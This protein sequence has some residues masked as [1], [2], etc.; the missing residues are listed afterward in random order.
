MS[1]LAGPSALLAASSPADSAA[2]AVTI[3]SSSTA[4]LQRCHRAVVDVW[5]VL[6]A[7]IA[8][9]SV[10]LASVLSVLLKVLLKV[11]RIVA[12]V[13]A[14]AL[15]QAAW[16]AWT[17]RSVRTLRK[18]LVFEAAVLVLGPGGNNLLLAL[19]WPGWAVLAAAVWAVWGLRVC[20]GW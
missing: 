4:V 1:L 9:H 14:Q 19:L 18:K 15:A 3:R 7:A 8:T 10:L 12:L 5:T 11:L 17:S 16:H 13:L 2:A 20:A 6:D